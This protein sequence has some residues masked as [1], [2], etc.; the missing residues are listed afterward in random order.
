MNLK[1][2]KTFRNIKRTFITGVLTLALAAPL[3]PA[4]DATAASIKISKKKLTLTVGK[5]HTLKIK[6]TKKKV[7]W[8]SSSKKI[9]TVSKKGKVKAKKVG[10]ATITA[11]VKSKTF[12]CKVTVKPK[13][14]HQNL[15]YRQNL[16]Y[17][18]S[19][20]TSLFLHRRRGQQSQNRVPTLP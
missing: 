8:K 16:K 10:T 19:R 6:G 20:R 14:Q 12:H 17:H 5:S 9:A 13:K 18:Q 2:R 15:R 4:S 11:K 3:I 1:N 7:T